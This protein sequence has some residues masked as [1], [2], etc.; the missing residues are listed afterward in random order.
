MKLFSCVT[1]ERYENVVTDN[2]WITLT[3]ERITFW[4]RN[5]S[6]NRRIH[7]LFLHIKIPF[8][9]KIVYGHVSHLTNF[10]KCDNIGFVMYPSLVLVANKTLNVDWDKHE[11]KW[12]KWE[13]DIFIHW[14][15]DPH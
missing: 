7:G 2:A 11:S 13:P 10:R 9:T 4:P 1:K 14:S 15:P 8:V 6:V 3:R 12:Y 5:K